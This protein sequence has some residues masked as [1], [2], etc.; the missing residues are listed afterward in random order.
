VSSAQLAFS[1][2]VNSIVSPV[3]YG[4]LARATRIVDVASMPAT[5]FWADW[6][7][8][9]STVEHTASATLHLAGWQLE[10]FYFEGRPQTIWETVTSNWDTVLASL[11]SSSLIEPVGHLTEGS[12]IDYLIDDW[13]AIARPVETSGLFAV[14]YKAVQAMAS[15]REGWDTYGASA[16]TA[17]ARD[18]AVRVLDRLLSKNLTPSK[19]LPSAEG[20]VAI[21]FTASSRRYA[22]IECF[23]SGDILAITSN[24]RSEPVVWA[25]GTESSVDDTIERIL[26]FLS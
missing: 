4:S 16:P 25:V 3:A 5:Y 20:G 6:E 1:T 10:D 23:N 13:T 21:S 11:A 15:L 2:L 22:D 17:I 7:K 18:N 19:V 14:H 9:V 12:I 24:R 26:V 8:K